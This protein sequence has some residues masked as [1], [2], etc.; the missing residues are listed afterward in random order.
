MP[1]QPCPNCGRLNRSGARFCASC[2]LALPRSEQSAPISTGPPCPNCRAANPPSAKFCNACGAALPSAAQR[3]AGATGALSLHAT[4]HNGRYVVEG[5]LGKGGMGA[6]YKVRDTHLQN[7]RWAIKEMSTAGLLTTEELRQGVEAF[8]REA[9]ML[10][11]LNHRNLPKV[12]DNFEESGREYLVMELVEGQTL[13][14][15]LGKGSKPLRVDQVVAWG[16]Q[17]C[18]VLGYL[19]SQRPAIIF[20]DLKPDNI[21]VDKDGVVKLIDFGI[22]RH[23]TPGKKVDTTAFGTTGY[24]PPEQYGKGQTDARSDV[25]ALAATLH[26]L[27]TQRDPSQDPFNFPPARQLNPNVP[28]DLSVALQKALAHSPA[29]RWMSMA[30]FRRALRAPAQAQPGPAPVAMPLA[31]PARPASPVA[32]PAPIVPTRTASPPAQ[33]QPVD[34]RRAGWLAYLIVVGGLSAAS[35]L[36]H[37]PNTF[38]TLQGLTGDGALSNLLYLTLIWIA[39]VLAYLLTR[40]PLAAFLVFSIGWWLGVLGSTTDLGDEMLQNALITAG[41]LEVTF[42]LSGYRTRGVLVGIV[43]AVLGAIAGMAL[44][45]IRNQYAP[46]AGELVV[47]LL[48]GLVGGALAALLATIL[49]R[50]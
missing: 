2:R 21:M 43:A 19:H 44:L 32:P 18:D 4:L 36:F 11:H 34:R 5:L 10:A 48:A 41:A 17:L 33:A 15:M 14:A 12:I 42:L 8:R 28:D 20:R 24:A 37:S 7:K 1:E 27:L 22:A 38:G 23:F 3:P 39:P 16:E 29:D 13:S 30:D 50:G 35:V 31:T 25:Y 6:V 26:H 49:G 46:S 40:R 47:A 9:A 45:I